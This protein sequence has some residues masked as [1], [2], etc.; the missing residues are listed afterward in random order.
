MVPTGGM[1]RLARKGIQAG[2]VRPGG[3]IQLAGSGD[4]DI[5]AQGLSVGGGDCPG[6]GGFVENC[7]G[8]VLIKPDMRGQV[9]PLNAA[10]HIA[11]N[12][13]LQPELT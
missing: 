1:K 11:K 2:N 3:L 10:L 7:A 5:G 6:V 9:V 13:R 12:F 8:D 4:D